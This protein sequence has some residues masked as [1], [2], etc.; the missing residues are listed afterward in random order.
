MPSI[1]IIVAVGVGAINV[2]LMIPG[3][4]ALLG[5]GKWSVR[6]KHSGRLSA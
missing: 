5:H 6:S 3:V 4:A 1:W 2:R